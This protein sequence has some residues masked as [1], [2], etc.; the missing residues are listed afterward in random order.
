MGL[1]VVAVAGCRCPRIKGQK[2]VR[3]RGIEILAVNSRLLEGIYARQL[4]DIPP[5]PKFEL[6]NT[7]ANVHFVQVTIL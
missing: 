5:F 4:F 6:V 3:L 2:Y 7:V 1:S